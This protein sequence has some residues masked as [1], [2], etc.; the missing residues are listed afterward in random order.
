MEAHDMLGIVSSC[1]DKE[2]SMTYDCV[3]QTSKPC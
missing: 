2:Y 1:Y 3:H